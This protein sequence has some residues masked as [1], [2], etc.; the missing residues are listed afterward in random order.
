MVNVGADIVLLA[1]PVPMTVM[2]PVTVADVIHLTA[3]LT[4]IQSPPVPAGTLIVPKSRVFPLMLRV[5]E[6]VVVPDS[7]ETKINASRSADL[8]SAD[9]EESVNV[10]VCDPTPPPEIFTSLPIPTF[11]MS[12]TK[13]VAST[14]PLKLPLV[15]YTKG[16]RRHFCR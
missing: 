11:A 7:E 10:I 13:V 14:D 8:P 5:M 1:V 12:P 3:C 6:T 9:V 4:V 15:A 2:V 16:Q